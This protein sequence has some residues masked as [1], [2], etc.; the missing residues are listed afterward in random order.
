M[1]ILDRLAYPTPDTPHPPACTCVE[2]VR[3]RTVRR[4]AR[5]AIEEP[6][7]LRNCES[8]LASVCSTLRI[9]KPLLLFNDALQ[10]P[11]ACGEA[12]QTTIWLHKQ[13]VLKSNW[14]D[15]QDTIDH[16]VAHIVVHNGS[17]GNEAPAHGLA[18]KTALEL[19]RTKTRVIRRAAQKGQNPRKKEK[20]K[21]RKEGRQE[22][23]LMLFRRI[24]LITRSRGKS[25]S[26]SGPDSVT[27]TVSE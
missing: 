10:N 8:Y 11:G 23:G 24:Y 6:S 26:T 7:R 19:V 12:G 2:C 3:T 4:T 16:E 14:T 13:H 20:Q 22:E 17:K 27:S 5:L 9:K 21:P 18:F 25:E 15:V 1:S